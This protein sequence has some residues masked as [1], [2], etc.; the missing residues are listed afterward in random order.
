[1]L[2]VFLFHSNPISHAI[3]IAAAAA[4]QGREKVKDMKAARLAATSVA[5]KTV[6]ATRK[7]QLVSP[8]TL[9]ATTPPQ[10]TAVPGEL[11]LK[12]FTEFASKQIRMR[13]D[14]QAAPSAGQQKEQH[15]GHRR[16]HRL[17]HPAARLWTPRAWPRRGGFY[18]AR[19]YCSH[20]LE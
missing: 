3:T 11:L 15:R 10:G 17:H 9:L 2:F 6:K 19:R 8:M 5:A 16:E 14:D 20:E 12:A 4:A 13:R 7:T 18:S 1:M